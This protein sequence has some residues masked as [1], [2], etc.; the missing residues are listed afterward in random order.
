MDILEH[1]IRP[2]RPMLTT[3]WFTV[4]VEMQQR[5]NVWTSTQLVTME[6]DGSWS[7]GLAAA[8]PFQQ[9]F[10]SADITSRFVVT[11]MV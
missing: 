3:L 5:Q 1:K 2:I 6:S 10:G 9:Q 11:C 8:K 4:V 7:P